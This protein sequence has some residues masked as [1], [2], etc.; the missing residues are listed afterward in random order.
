M[1]QIGIDWIKISWNLNLHPDNVSNYEVQYSYAGECDIIWRG[2]TIRTTGGTN[3][4][5]NITALGAYLNYSI[6]LIAVNDTG[7]SP[8]YTDFARTRPTGLC[9]CGVHG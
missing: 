9:M 1:H 7:R 4:S 8:P 6:T 5:Y 3:S 2:S